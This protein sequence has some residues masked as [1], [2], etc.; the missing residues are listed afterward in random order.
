LS[1]DNCRCNTSS[2]HASNASVFDEGTTIHFIYS[3]RLS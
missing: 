3:E 2:Q 1:V